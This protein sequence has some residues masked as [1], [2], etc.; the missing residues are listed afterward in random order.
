MPITYT[1]RKGVTY[2]LRQTVTKTGKPRYMFAREP[3][4]DLV[5]QIP[6]GWHI[7]ENVNGIVS[8]AKDRPQQILLGEVAAVEAQIERHPKPH[9]YRVTVKEDRVE[10]YERAGP[11]VEGIASHFAQ[12]GLEIAYHIEEL[13][14]E[15]DRHARFSPVLR[16]ILVDEEQ[17]TFRTQRW[18]Y[19][20]SIDDWIEVG[21]WGP[22][23]LLA[24]QWVPR[25]GTDAF[26]GVYQ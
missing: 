24:R 3:K 6:E 1:N 11:D 25:L 26:F 19:L 10:V 8:L 17:R 13:R 5:E 7:Q 12:A 16:F 21:P 22:V 18:C 2:Y 23:D 20:G 14:A 15:M 4:G 9:D